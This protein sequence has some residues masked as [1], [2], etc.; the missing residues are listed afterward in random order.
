MNMTD[1]KAALEVLEGEHELIVEVLAALDAYCNALT[2]GNDVD[3]G[4]LGKFVEFVRDFVDAQHHGKEEQVLFPAM[5]EAGFPRAGR[6]GPLSVMMEEHDLGRSTL[7]ELSTFAEA[8]S[9]Q[10]GASAGI[11]GAG[12][13]FSELMR[14]HIQKENNLL[15]P[16]ARGRL[17]GDQ[18]S[19]LDS[20]CAQLDADWTATDRH[21]ELEASARVLIERYR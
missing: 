18:M 9:W 16:M 14:A 3:K 10:E 21:R 20:R 4:D 12:H 7:A 19:K 8:E 15:Y 2:S 11:S 13:R 17:T 6:P 1:D 5:A